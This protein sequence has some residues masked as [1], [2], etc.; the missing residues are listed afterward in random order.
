MFKGQAS[1]ILRDGAGYGSYFLAYEW[2]V[3]RHIR[4]NN[5]KREDIS[6]LWAV[7]YGAAAGFA[8]WFSIYPVDVIKSKLQTDS[9]DPAKRQYKGI[10]DC[11]LKTW[12][13]QGWR[14]FTGGLGPTLLR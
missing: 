14:G 3:Q 13:A 2:L 1:T 4:V 6:P 8:L 9:L 10:V 11:G 5:V 7:T 12:R